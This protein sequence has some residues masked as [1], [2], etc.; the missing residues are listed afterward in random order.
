MLSDSVLAVTRRRG[1]RQRRPC[2]PRPRPQPRARPRQS[3]LVRC[4]TAT[5]L[6]SRR[7]S[8]LAVMKSTAARRP[9]QNSCRTS[10]LPQPIGSGLQC[11]SKIKWSAPSPFQV[12]AQSSHTENTPSANAP[13]D[14]DLRVVPCRRRGKH[15]LVERQCRRM[16]KQFP[17][18]AQ[19]E[20]EDPDLVA[21][22]DHVVS[23][24]DQPG[25]LIK[26]RKM[27][28]ERLNHMQAQLSG[29]GRAFL[30]PASC[31]V[32]ARSGLKQGRRGH[33]GETQ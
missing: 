2:R 24:F 21:A 31:G 3:P 20:I 16:H 4:S 25:Q 5:P 32:A 14:R 12:R 15:F 30:D 27:I 11:L 8:L 13:A 19:H 22:I 10:R 6:R 17:R 1:R 18:T 7:Q 33:G 23:F 9:Q 28:I 29:P 26:R